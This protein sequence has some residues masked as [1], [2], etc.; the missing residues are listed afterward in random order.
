MVR[1]DS[2]PCRPCSETISW[3]CNVTLRILRTSNLKL[4]A[5]WMELIP[6]KDTHLMLNHFD[7][8]PEIMTY[9]RTWFVSVV[10]ILL[11][12]M[13]IQFC[14]V[15]F[16]SCGNVN[17]HFTDY[18]LHFMNSL[19]SLSLVA[20]TS[21]KLDWFGEQE[22][23]HMWRT[24]FAMQDGHLSR[25]FDASFMFSFRIF[26][27]GENVDQYLWL[28]SMTTLLVSN[29]ANECNVFLTSCSDIEKVQK[30]ERLRNRAGTEAGTPL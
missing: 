3:S 17:F 24:K 10:H 13:Q 25:K 30:K 5:P 27:C 4:V 8:A 16:L 9:L 12:N 1:K 29:A 6:R 7:F 11:F 14:D 2:F 26:T 20:R 23:S 18:W 28:L 19:S 15:F 21:M 22:K